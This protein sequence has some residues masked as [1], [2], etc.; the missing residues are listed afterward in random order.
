[1]SL[2]FL[3]PA[4]FSQGTTTSTSF[5]ISAPAMAASTS[6]YRELDPTT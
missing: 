3:A 4:A 1:M 5:P 6:A 2:G